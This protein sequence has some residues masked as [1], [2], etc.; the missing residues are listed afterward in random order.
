MAGFSALARWRGG[1]WRQTKNKR[2]FFL[3][4]RS[5]IPQS[6]ECENAKRE[7]FPKK[8]TLCTANAPNLR[9]SSGFL[10]FHVATEAAKDRVA[11][12][13]KRTT[14][15]FGFAQ[16]SRRFRINR[17]NGEDGDRVEYRDEFSAAL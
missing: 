9:E 4:Q 6:T 16:A 8:R 17:Q 14:T 7:D 3:P 11:A 5:Q 1:H 13:R 10:P 12:G 15:W 2:M